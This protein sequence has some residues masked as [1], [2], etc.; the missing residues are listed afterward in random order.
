MCSLGN[1]KNVLSTWE[2]SIEILVNEIQV[3]SLECWDTFVKGKDLNTQLRIE[4]DI[5]RYYIFQKYWF[6]MGCPSPL[7]MCAYYTSTK[8]KIAHVHSLDI[9]HVVVGFYPKS[10][11]DL[12]NYTV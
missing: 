8:H 9:M 12:I 11:N 7:Y 6:L 5:K 1:V 2:S 3:L 10:I 4:I